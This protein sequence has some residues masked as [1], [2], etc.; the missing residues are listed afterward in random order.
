MFPFLFG[1]LDA[2][3]EMESNIQQS[4]LGTLTFLY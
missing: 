2:I 4:G 3:P 1:A